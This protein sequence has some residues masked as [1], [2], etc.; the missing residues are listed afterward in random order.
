MSKN[1]K[2]ISQRVLPEDETKIV[3]EKEKKNNKISNLGDPSRATNIQPH[4]PDRENAN[5]EDRKV[6]DKGENKEQVTNSEKLSFAEA[7]KTQKTNTPNQP[8]A[9]RI[10]DKKTIKEEI[11]QRI[12]HTTSYTP[13][14]TPTGIERKV[15]EMMTTIQRVTGAGS[16][17]SIQYKG[18]GEYAI[19]MKTKEMIQKITLTG[20]QFPG[21]TQKAPTKPRRNPVLLITIKTDASTL[22]QEIADAL[23][24][25]GTIININYGYY[26]NNRQIRDGRRLIHIIPTV[27]IDKIPSSTLIDYRTH[28]LYF[29]GKT[30]QTKPP[31]QEARDLLEDLEISDS[32]L[33]QDEM[34]QDE[35]K[36]IQTDTPKTE[37]K[38]PGQKTESSKLSK[39]DTTDTLENPTKITEKTK[40]PTQL[41]IAI[42]TKQK[43]ETNTSAKPQARNATETVTTNK[44][45]DLTD[46]VN[47]PLALD[48]PLAISPMD[49]DMVSNESVQKPIKRKSETTPTKIDRQNTDNPIK[50]KRKTHRT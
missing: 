32:D 15:T 40:K 49:T 45:N 18:R 5:I 11:H 19:E 35:D 25:Y 31:H 12:F 42:S 26:N 33:D 2:N 34:S 37:T 17:T 20:L 4:F 22:N 44:T 23:S 24:P 28:I 6:A 50:T 13:D 48:L 3:N 43:P 1:L 47:I 7:L 10:A 46:I 39:K 27:D 9:S 36:Q 41:P 30:I 14:Q 21:D 16:I 8:P 29:R 38:T